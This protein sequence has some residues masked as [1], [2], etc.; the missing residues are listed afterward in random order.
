MKDI[1]KFTVG[2]NAFFK[3]I[4]GFVP[5]D[6]DMLYIMD[7][8]DF[9]GRSAIIRKDDT[10]MLLYPDKGLGLIDDC[11]KQ[12]DPLTAGKFLVPEFCNYIGATISDISVL[13]SLFDKMDDK[14]KYETYIFKCYLGNK[15]MFLT[16]EQLEKAYSLYKE[17]R[18]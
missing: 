11:T 17:S 3:D 2:S 9:E 15:D 5:H 10:D 4:E 13:S 14:H 7:E 1:A 6:N 12:N 8:W 16:S 18:E